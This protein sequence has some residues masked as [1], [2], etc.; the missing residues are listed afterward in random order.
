MGSQLKRLFIKRTLLLVR[1]RIVIVDMSRDA[2][3]FDVG[4]EN[5]AIENRGVK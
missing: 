3:G 2:A 1:A 5:R 4:I